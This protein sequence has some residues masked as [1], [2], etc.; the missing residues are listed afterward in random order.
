MD[1]V[2]AII[3]AERRI[4]PFVRETPLDYSAFLSALTGAEV[5]LKLENMQ[6]T[7]SFK[8]RG[9]LNAL[10]C[11]NSAER[12]CGI[13]AASSGNHGMAI[14]FGMR[15]LGVTGV[16]FVP[17]DASPTKIAAIRALGAAVR[18]QGDDCLVAEVAARQYAIQ[19]GMSYLSPYND[20]RVVTGQGTL[21]VE[22]V[23]QAEHLDAVF[24]AVGGGGLVSGVAAYM[25]AQ[26]PDVLVVGCQPE[27]SA[28]MF[29]SLRAGRIVELPDRPTL[30]DGTAG[31]IEAG[32]VTFG[33]C[34]QLVDRFVLVSEEEIGAA[35][36]LA[37]EVQH[38]L[39]EGAAG[40]ALAAF[41]RCAEEFRG[42]RVAVVLCGANVSAATL[43]TVL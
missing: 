33:L 14:A 20:L 19:Q 43:K 25:K 26:W 34:Q 38:T 42:M 17:E 30:S 9:A 8:V 29:E 12:E 15:A 11:L 10:L 32:S 35:M 31:G 2:P 1:V 4:R 28:V 5:L 3:E 21:G 7:G 23:R 36:R 24:V 13:V 18:Q 6:H 37:I 16:V 40:V 22:L 41:L 39:I 27:R